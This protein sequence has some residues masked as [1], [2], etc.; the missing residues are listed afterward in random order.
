MAL[1]IQDILYLY[2]T[3]G[4]DLHGGEA[5]TQLDHAL[6]C[7]RLA[8]EAGSP[9]ELVVACMLHDVGHLLARRSQSAYG[10]VDVH[11]YLAVPLLRDLLPGAVVDPIRLHVDAKRYLCYSDPGYLEQLSPSS[12]RSLELQGGAFDAEGAHRFLREPHA[13]E[14]VL[15]RRFDDLARDPSRAAPPL[16]HYEP[17]LRACAMETA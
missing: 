11:A 1:R 2:K 17:V 13:E 14:A 5:L 12:R 8:E 4:A 7:A 9:P 6:Q 16:S 15:L 10:G 3:R